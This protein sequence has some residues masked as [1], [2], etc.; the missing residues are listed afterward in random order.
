MKSNPHERLALIECGMVVIF[1]E[2]RWNRWGFFDKCGHLMHWWPVIAGKA[3]RGKKGSFWHVPLN[4]TANSGGKLRAV[5][6]KDP[7]E[8]K[9]ER[10]KKGQV[11][12]KRMPSKRTVPKGE[13]GR[14]HDDDLFSYASRQKYVKG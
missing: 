3:R 5:S 8:L 1:F 2:P 7:H 6:N 9:L 11:S 12:K 14:Q 13:V 4:W 10:R